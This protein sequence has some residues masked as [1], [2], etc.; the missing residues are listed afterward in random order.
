MSFLPLRKSSSRG[1]SEIIGAIILLALTV[2]IGLAVFV[3]VNTSEVTSFVTSERGSLNPNVIPKLKITGYDTR[4]DAEL[5]GIT[6][7]ENQLSGGGSVDDLCAFSCADG[8][9]EYIILRVRNDGDIVVEITGVSIN[10]VEHTWHDASSNAFGGSTLPGSGEFIIISGFG[11]GSLI[12]EI[13]SFLP[14]ASEKR[15]VIRLDHDDANLPNIALNENIRVIINSSVETTQLVLV[16][17]GSL[18]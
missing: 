1:V 15:L 4:D 7:I 9:T 11:T 13:T 8:A 3:L 16:P 10:E 2:T 5:Y 14:E 6:E 18:I 17:A 12:Q